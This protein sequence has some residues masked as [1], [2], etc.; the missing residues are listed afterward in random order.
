M[1]TCS[2]CEMQ[3]EIQENRSG[4]CGMYT[5]H[6]GQIHERFPNSYLIEY[7]VSIETIPFLHFYPKNKFLQ[8]STVGCNFRCIGCV[9][10]LLTRTA[11][12]FTPSLI[13][14]SP[15]DVV[16][17]A[18]NEKCKGIVFA[19][20]DPTVSFPT[21]LGLADQAKKAGLLI[22]C[23][24]NGYFTEE[25][26]SQMIPV[27]D[28][29]AV[30]I[31]GCDDAAYHTCGVRSSEP[32]FRNI[33]KLVD[34]GIHVEV[35][36][37]YEKGSEEDLVKT[38]KR[39]VKI[40]P[41]IPILVMRFIPFGPADLALEPGI[42]A[43]E[44]MCDRLREYARYVYLFNSPGSSYLQTRC[45]ECGQVIVRR[46]FYGPMGARVIDKSTQWTCSCG[47]TIPHTGTIAQETY[48]EEGM[49]G[50]YRPTRALEIIKAIT[51]C[52]DIQD[53]KTSAKVWMDFISQNY[54]DILHKKIQK[55]ETFYEVIAHLAEI[56]GTVHK[57]AQLISYIQDRTAY[58]SSLVQ[59]KQRPRVLY[60]MGTPLFLL[61]EDRFENAMVRAAGGE[62]VNINLTR[63]GKPGIMVDPALI[64]QLN[65]DVIMVSGFLATPLED[66]YAICEEQGI[67]VNAVR[68]HRIHLMPPSWDFGSPRFVLGLF[69]LVSVLHPD[70]TVEIEKEAELFY[71]QFY[72]MS[73]A[74]AKPNRSF[75]RA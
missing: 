38:V 63:K 42:R 55:I 64:N 65:P 2:V 49:M 51:T 6:D 74:E 52:L 1:T 20:N 11:T 50:G 36:V 72:H 23:S 43:S 60:V 59:N 53:E 32:V 67:D 31:K 3:C 25:S 33:K 15:K 45:P 27:V 54:I 30:G 57:G 48:Q 19:L 66:M 40:S 17:R 24:T 56:T 73:Y 7:P 26:L 62:P 5:C 14:T 37:V 12:E 71:Q 58:I 39:V 69:Y 9:S 35:T 41:E 8:V 46:E 75:F 28:A 4:S 68:N 29:V 61:N 44:E 10:D 16:A 22:G 13:H 70:C 18:V 34:S 21:F 47:C